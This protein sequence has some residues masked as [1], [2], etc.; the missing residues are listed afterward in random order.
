[1]NMFDELTAMRIKLQSWARLQREGLDYDGKVTKCPWC[2]SVDDCPH[3][4]TEYNDLE[5]ELEAVYAIENIVKEI[6]KAIP[7]FNAFGQPIEVQS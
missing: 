7:H 1:M 5:K 4:P 6:N 3:D 2:E